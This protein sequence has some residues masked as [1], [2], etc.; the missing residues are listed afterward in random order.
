KVDLA[1]NG[2]LIVWSDNRG[3]DWDIFGFDFYNRFERPLVRSPGDQR[4]PEMGGD[5]LVWQDHRGGDWDVRALNISSGDEMIVAEGRGSQ[6]NPSIS[7][8]RVAWMDNSSGDWKVMVKDLDGAAIKPPASGAGDQIDPV[9]SGDLLV[10]QDDRS[11]DWDVYVCDLAT[12]EETKLTGEGDQIAPH[13]SGNTIVWEDSA[14]GDVNYYLWDK[15]WGRDYERPGGQH[16]PKVHG[17]RIA[18]EEA[19]EDG[20]S[21]HSFDPNTWKDKEEARSSGDV[22]FDFDTRLAWL[23]S[24]SARFGYVNLGS[25]Q[26]SVICQASGDQTSAAVSGNWVVWMDNRTQNPDI[27]LYNLV[28]NV[29]WPLAAGL[30]LDMYP[31]IN[32][33]VVVWMY[34]EQE[35]DS[36]AIRALDIPSVNRTQ[37]QRGIS[38]PTRPSISEEIL[39]W[40]DLPI[41][42]FGWDVQKKPLYNTEAREAIPPRADQ[43]NPDAGGSVVVYQD[44]QKGDWDIYIWSGQTRTPLYSGPGNQSDPT[45]DGATV[46]WQDDRNGNWDLYSADLATGQVSQLTSDPSDQTNPHL[47]NGILVW[48]DDR[49]G[50][51]DIRAMD[52]STGTEMEIFTGP[53][54]Q[55]E[56]RTGSDKIVWIDDQKGDKDVYM[57]EIYRE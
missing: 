20:W 50:D 56:P 10:W 31:D 6:M 14:T 9:V 16:K 27:Y 12:G 11:G 29:E 18:Y 39:A 43:M 30:D 23:I 13:V 54:N 47:K 55:I 37:L 57:Y 17:K 34:L 35:F 52:I 46:V 53:G 21:I 1:T 51:W 26:T 4:R 49:N 45:T 19:T 3:G 42:S 15:K 28:E 38:V 8:R 7:G 36:W 25:D 24:P 44:N 5:L 33:D 2:S 41:A 48:Q 22:E 32:N 40:A